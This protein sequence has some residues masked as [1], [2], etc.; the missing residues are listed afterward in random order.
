MVGQTDIDRAG[1]QI[2]LQ[3]VAGINVDIDMRVVELEFGE[4]GNVLGEAI[5]DTAHQL[6]G[7]AA[8]LIVPGLARGTDDFDMRDVDA[9]TGAEIGRPILARLLEAIDTVQ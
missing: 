8:K 6:A 1:E 2:G 5:V 3:L 4:A 9:D 7:D